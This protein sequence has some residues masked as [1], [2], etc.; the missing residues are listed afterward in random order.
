MNLQTY[1]HGFLGRFEA[2]LR[3]SVEA[4]DRRYTPELMAAMRYTLEAVLAGLEMPFDAGQRNEAALFGLIC[5]SEDSTSFSLFLFRRTFS[6]SNS[7]RSRR[8]RTYFFTC[9]NTASDR[10]F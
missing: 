3:A 6:F 7:S 8:E 5:S 4:L 2:P 1:L 9:I 10:S